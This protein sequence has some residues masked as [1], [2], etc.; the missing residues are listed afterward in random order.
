MSKW[1]KALEKMGLVQLEEGDVASP[2]PEIEERGDLELE[3]SEAYTDLQ[4]EPATQEP[5]LEE[6]VNVE[7]PFK[8]REIAQIYRDASIASSPYPIERMIKLLEGLKAMPSHMRFQVIKA[9]DVADD[10][11][12]IE[13]SILDGQRKKRAIEQERNRI[14]L[15]LE[16]RKAWFAEQKKSLKQHLAD[17]H[18]E[19]QAQITELE[20]LLHE[21]EQHITEKTIE[22]EMQQKSDQTAF[23]NTMD[24]L[25]NH[26]DSINDVL[27]SIQK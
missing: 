22:L 7:T 23:Q 1:L 19:I 3:N 10:S 14:V 20:K 17:A 25:Q 16:Q 15:E 9:M 11:W 5:I 18:A 8:V 21:E 13:D 4:N 24:S 6:E 26:L 27:L 2:L 12:T